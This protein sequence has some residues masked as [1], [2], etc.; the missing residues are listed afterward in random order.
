MLINSDHKPLESIFKKELSSATPRIQRMRLKLLRYNVTIK[1]KPGKYLFIADA[2][3]RAF[4]NNPD[5]KSNAEIEYSV[6]CVTKY[7]PISDKRKLQISGE[8]NNDLVLKQVKTFIDTCWPDK[9]KIIGELKHFFKIREELYVESDLIFFKNKLVLPIKMKAE[10][11][12]LL[13]QGHFGI[14]KTKALARSIFYWPG[15]AKDVEHFVKSC[16]KCERFAR[17]NPKQSLLPYP[18]P[19][20]P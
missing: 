3:S 4:L 20:R 8:I 5:L 6:H 18:L 9:N 2:L 14:E 12:Q 10:M 1:Y 15:Q 16:K 7:L 17:K 11:L 13:H 19:Q